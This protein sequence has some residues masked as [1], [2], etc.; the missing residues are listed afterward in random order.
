MQKTQ[1]NNTPPHNNEKRSGRFGPLD[2]LLKLQTDPVGLDH[3]RK[4]VF[5]FSPYIYNLVE[6]NFEPL[7]Y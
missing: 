4:P 2:P 5:L 1:T 6:T 7:Q 3:F